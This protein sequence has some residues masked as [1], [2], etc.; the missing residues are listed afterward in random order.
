MAD[1]SFDLSGRIALVTGASSGFGARF[2]RQLAASGAKVALGARR[3]DLLDDLAD[4]IAG[5]GG[6]AL[7]VEMDVSDEASVIAAYDRVEEEFGTPDSIVANAG[8]NVEGP[9]TELS[10]DDFN[11]LMG[12]NL[13]GVFLT[14]R[15]GARRLMAAGSRERG[16]GRIVIVSSITANTVEPGLAAYSASKAAVQQMGKVLARDWVRQGINVNSICPGYVRTEINSDW[17]DTEPGQKQIA[18]FHRRRLMPEDSLDAMLLYLA[19]D[20]SAAITGSSFT[21]D[22]GQ[23][24]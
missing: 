20:A 14:V 9:A 6:E 3:V 19:S 15:E 17:F 22:D 5:A 16:H 11:R 8:M 2:A 23:S 7:A 21:L 1:F 18:K 13:T 4:E 24:L 10:A 12:V